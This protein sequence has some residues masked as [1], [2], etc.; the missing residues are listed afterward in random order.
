MWLYYL[1]CISI[2]EKNAIVILFL[3]FFL[4]QVNHSKI[5]KLTLVKR[6]VL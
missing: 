4:K 6:Q 3:H 5:N 2:S 1:Y